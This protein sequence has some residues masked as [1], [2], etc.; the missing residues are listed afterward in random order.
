M[1]NEE[2]TTAAEVASV[3]DHGEMTGEQKDQDPE[4]QK[5]EKVPPAAE[6]LVEDTAS[7]SSREDNDDE[8]E[9]EVE[10]EE[11][12][13]EGEDEEEKEEDPMP[14]LNFT[15]LF[16][17]LPRCPPQPGDNQRPFAVASTC[18]T[19]GQ[20]ILSPSDTAVSSSANTTITGNSIN[21]VSSPPPT[22]NN[23]AQHRTPDATTRQAASLPPTMDPLLSQEPHYVVAMGFENGML[24]LVEARTG[25]AVVPSHRLKLRED[26]REPIVDVSMDSSGTFLAAVDAGRMA[27]VWEFKYTTAAAANAASSS[28]QPQPQPPST[29]AAT[30]QPQQ[31]TAT[32][33]TAEVGVFSSFMSAFTGSTPSTSGNNNTAETTPSP[34]PAA[35][36]LSTTSHVSLAGIT[37]SSIQMTRISY[38]RSFGVPTCIA[39][40]PAYKRKREK[41]VL[42]G[43]LDGRL[44]L[45]KRGMIFQRRTDAIIYQGTYESNA[46]HQGIEAIQWRGCLAAWADATGIRL[47]DTETLT[48]IA[49]IDRPTGARPTL[50][51]TLSSL[52]P[53]LRF[54][55]S[56]YLLVAW[57]DCL[58]GL[59]ITDHSQSSPSSTT[60]GTQQQQAS[61]EA[62]ASSSG[63]DAAQGQQQQQPV[64]RRRTVECAMAWE[65]DCVACGVVP[66]DSEHCV[67][68]GLVAPSDEDDEEAGDDSQSNDLEVQ[69]VAKRDGSI[70]YSSILPML[71]RDERNKPKE[72]GNANAQAIVSESA[73]SYTLLSSFA[74][75]RMEDVFEAQ[76]ENVPE[77]DFEIQVSLFSPSRGKRFVDS[78][79][80][81]DIQALA[82]DDDDNDTFD[83]TKQVENEY[84]DTASVDSDDYG[85]I[86][87][88]LSTPSEEETHTDR[89]AVPPLMVIASS[90]DAILSRTR[91][92][93]D[94][95][96]HAL[97][98]GKSA[99]VIRR[100]LRQKRRLRRFDISKLVD[101]YFYSLLRIPREEKETEGEGDANDD[102]AKALSIRRL[103]LAARAMPALFGSDIE[104]WEKWVSELENIPGALFV[105]S[106]HLPVRGK[107]LLQGEIECADLCIS[108]SSHLCY[109]LLPLIDP[110]LPKEL[111]GRVL[112]RMLGEIDRLASSADS[113]SETEEHGRLTLRAEECFLNTLT[114]WGPTNFLKEH[115]KLCKYHGGAEDSMMRETIQ[116]A[117]DRFAC[118]FTQTS[119]GYLTFPVPTA[120]N[121]ESRAHIRS[122]S[123]YDTKKALFDV[124]KLL[125]I[126]AARTPVI[127]GVEVPSDS[128]KDG[129][130]DPNSRVALD[131]T[132]RLNMMKGQFDVALKYFLAI[133]A[134]HST[135]PLAEFETGAIQFSESV[136]SRE[137]DIPWQSESGVPYTFVLEAIES[138]HLHQCLLDEQFLSSLKSGKV[139]PLLSLLK[140]VGLAAMG[141][142]LIEHCVSPQTPVNEATEADELA[143]EKRGERRGTLPLDL[144]AQQ[145]ASHPKLLHWYLHLVFTRNPE[146]Y[147]KFPNTAYPPKSVT[148]LHRKHF[149]LYVAFAGAEVD[150][151]QTLAGVENYKVGSVSTR[152]LDFLK[153]SQSVAEQH[154]A[155]RDNPSQFF[156]SPNHPSIS[157]YRLRC[158]LEAYDLGMPKAL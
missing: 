7:S 45:T 57:G 35:A 81:W 136:G 1:E 96:A 69:I 146:I 119:A 13:D 137:I 107:K 80:K 109:A 47:F 104:L 36:E 83:G 94:A 17:A 153:V 120:P 40:D 111:Y 127:S 103:K 3:G 110:R 147:V 84:D 158:L 15:R 49:H 89:T 64:V 143:N 14:L 123:Y 118:R 11:E 132:A 135:R 112:Y 61:T 24:E 97:A 113:K 41:A 77:E 5:E 16:G 12:R 73:A 116:D 100:A 156:S 152:L 75:P 79:L 108:M 78:H 32:G 140:L 99:L 101:E 92:V 151:V 91:D 6:E 149:D 19:M 124:D 25:L 63:G 155:H 148:D 74:L 139:L 86:F 37:A 43:F 68:L 71:R 55:T 53:T 21:P 8:E 2:G 142:F 82:F 134:L 34:P 70:L 72:R 33:T 52:R 141:D 26:H 93:D 50:Y 133:A 76:D 22:N 95:V 128:L 44:V 9:E 122:E 130:N 38:P 39:M 85:F 54:E 20:V 67:V 65:L 30:T 115:I 18:A 51:P 131:A 87:R 29:P 98:A 56:Q 88:P 59:S 125:E 150:S 10:E 62:A 121:K 4:Q 46:N 114:G 138:H 154:R 28:Q 157:I 58:M 145:L 42:T 60:S 117:E 105:L 66:F 144:V 90:S 23:N 48:R 102:K 31:G 27:C 126:F 106:D 129:D